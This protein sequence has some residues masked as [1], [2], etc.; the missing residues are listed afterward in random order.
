MSRPHW[1]MSSYHPPHSQTS[2]FD[3]R[4][5]PPRL[6][7]LP[8]GG[9]QL[10]PSLKIQILIHPIGLGGRAREP[11]GV[12]GDHGHTPAD[13]QPV[14]GHRGTFCLRGRG[15]VGAEHEPVYEQGA[16]AGVDWFRRHNT[17]CVSGLRGDWKAGDVAADGCEVSET[18]GMRRGG[19]GDEKGLSLSDFYA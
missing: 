2:L 13:P 16:A 8:F 15:G 7:L 17:E 9:S 14:R 1:G 4:I 19:L 6:T 11:A 12:E 10:R 3:S 5:T 18:S